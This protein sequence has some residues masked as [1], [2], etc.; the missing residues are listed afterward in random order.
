M[1]WQRPSNQ[2]L[3]PDPHLVPS[4]LPLTTHPQEDRPSTSLIT[5][6]NTPGSGI[7]GVFFDLTPLVE[8]LAK[9]FQGHKVPLGPKKL[10]VGEKRVLGALEAEGCVVIAFRAELHV[11]VVDVIVE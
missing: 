8:I 2:T 5:P 1:K 11:G 7:R 6:K 3:N 4:S 9:V 10:G